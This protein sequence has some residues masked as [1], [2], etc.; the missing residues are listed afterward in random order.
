MGRIINLALVVLFAVVAVNL[1][2]LRFKRKEGDED[3]YKDGST[4]E[5]KGIRGTAPLPYR[6][7]NTTLIIT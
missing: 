6:Y 5:E 3:G 1:W 2:Y 7:L 4:G